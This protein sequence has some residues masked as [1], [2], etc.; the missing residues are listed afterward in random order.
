MF[1][2]LALNPESRNFE[3]RKLFTSPDA[4][5][6]SG[7][8]WNPWITAYSV[9]VTLD[10]RRSADRACS[11]LAQSFCKST[12]IHNEMASPKRHSGREPGRTRSALR[13]DM[14]L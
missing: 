8:T 14:L 7:A 1:A 11:A 10:G 6:L 12:N 13:C 4:R 5:A 2:Q 9:V 3:S